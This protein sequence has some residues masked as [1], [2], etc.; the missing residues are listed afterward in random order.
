V[1][2]LAWDDRDGFK[3]DMASETAKVSTK[4]LENFTDGFGLLFVDRHVVK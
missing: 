3:T 4:D 1:A 2:E